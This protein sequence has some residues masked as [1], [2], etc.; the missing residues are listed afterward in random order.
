MKTLIA[1]RQRDKNGVSEDYKIFAHTISGFI[2]L[3]E[4]AENL[5][6]A[7]IFGWVV[8]NKFYDESYTLGSIRRYEFECMRRLRNLP[9][10]YDLLRALIDEKR[11]IIQAIVKRKG[12]KPIRELKELEEI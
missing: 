4:K 11:R 6:E 2:E 5:P 1:D 8:P 12:Y 7:E 3:E 9:S 10:Y